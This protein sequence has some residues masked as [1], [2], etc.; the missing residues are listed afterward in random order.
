MRR[1]RRTLPVMIGRR[2]LV[3]LAALSVVAL[4]AG[5]PP[6]NASGAPA[7]LSERNRRAPTVVKARPAP[8]ADVPADRFDLA[9]GCYA[10]RA[11][12]GGWVTRTA[13]GYA[14][15]ASSPAT[16]EPFHLQ[17]TDLGSYLLYGKAA[18]FLA[19][20]SGTSV[21]AAAAPSPAA[22]FVLDGQPGTGATLVLADQRALA[23]A[24][25]G[26]LQTAATPGRFTFRHTSGCAVFP[27]IGTGV[28]GPVVGGSTR[29]TEAAGYLDAHLHTMAFEFIGGNARCGRP[30]H[31]YGVTFAL[32][33]CPDHAAGGRGAVLEHVLSGTDPVRGHDTVGWPSFGYWP[34]Y[35]SLTHEQVYYTWLERAYR[36][37]LRQMT[38]LLVE[39]GAL[40]K[41]YPLKKN[42]CNEM[43]SVRLQ[44]QE[45]RAFE[46]Y[47]DAQSGGPGEGWFRI[48]TSPTQARQV[49]NDGKLAVVMG[50]E[51]SQLFD[52]TQVLLVA[53]CDAASIDRQ[54]DEVQQLGVRQLELTNKFDNALSGVTGDSGQTG[55]VVNQANKSETGSYWRMATCVPPPDDHPAGGHPGHDH[56][57]DRLQTSAATGTPAGQRDSIFAG[58]L[59]V[60]GTTGAA[61]VYPAGPHCNTLGLSDLGKRVLDGIVQRGMLFDPDHMSARA[62]HQALDYL[63]SKGYAGIVSSHSWS[64]DTLYPR[65]IAQGGVVTPYAGGSESFVAQW[66]KTVGWAAATDQYW[67]FGYGA[68]TNGFGSQGAPRGASAKTPV[69]YPF[70]GF[71]GVTVDRQRSGTRTYDVN[72]DGVAHY[73]LYADWVQDLRML[74]G[75]A[76]V[77]DLERGPESYLQ[78][79]ER[80]LGIEGRRCHPATE[81]TSGTGLGALRVGMSPEQVLATAG[82]PHIRNGQVFTYCIEGGQ[83]AAAT[84][85]GSARLVQVTG[86]SL[87]GATSPGAAGPASGVPAGGGA[88]TGRPAGTAAGSGGA[89][90]AATGGL[91]LAAVGLASLL[92]FAAV[93]RR[94]RAARDAAGVG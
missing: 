45:L 10:M 79:W 18:D 67:G 30:W 37:G 9:G 56:G 36:A 15:T 64:D 81:L 49:I 86:R 26:T 66:K 50:I 2:V 29:Y 3:P 65:V 35:D 93:H 32:Q 34:K 24:A 43:D 22:D 44:A 4:A 92:G 7:E 73:G 55:M 54:L 72:V 1:G 68:D 78:S 58:V 90:L 71:G 62:R 25:D 21:A 60:I 69:T 8:R 52:C 40:C 82:Q 87:P 46:R 85:D 31:R 88:V 13:G 6:A 17:A 91:P 41:L 38:T 12:G 74:A 16:A 20:G 51:I 77:R 83:A 14:A 28:T 11:V 23:V 63:K 94:R 33:D 75:D 59:T 61:P 84:F 53:G 27:E 89:T 48:V 47:I 76:I 5:L 19:A 80:A 39:N 57:E 70:T 42:S